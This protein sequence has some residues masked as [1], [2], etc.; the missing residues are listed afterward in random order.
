M[1][2]FGLLGLR[3]LHG[4]TRFN[5]INGFNG[6]GKLGRQEFDLV[7]SCRRME[8]D[9]PDQLRGRAQAHAASGVSSG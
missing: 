1:S 9:Q 2:L 7:R 5:C 4:L 3:G 8:S 6:F